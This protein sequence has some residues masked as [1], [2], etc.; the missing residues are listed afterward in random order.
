M[1]YVDAIVLGFKFW[2][3]SWQ[4]ISTQYNDA[5]SLFHSSHSIIRF[6]ILLILP[7]VSTFF[8]HGNIYLLLISFNHF[9]SSVAWV[10]L[11][12]HSLGKGEWQNS[13]TPRFGFSE[14]YFY[15]IKIWFFQENWI[16]TQH[17]TYLFLFPRFWLKGT[18]LFSIIARSRI[19]ILSCL[20]VP[21]CVV[22]LG[23]IELCVCMRIYLNG[24]N[25]LSFRSMLSDSELVLPVLQFSFLCFICQ[26]S[27]P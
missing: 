10:F 25:C 6:W 13:E 23:W 21:L 4:Q 9:Q 8:V 27:F 15:I 18:P 20:R 22:I 2:Q 11:F 5:H 19:H 3:F 24:W 1:E 14:F 7:S 26:F 16:R 12:F 17:V